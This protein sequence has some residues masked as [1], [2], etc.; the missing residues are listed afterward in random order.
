MVHYKLN[1]KVN[2]F[3]HKKNITLLYFLAKYFDHISKHG[4]FHPKKKLVGFLTL[5]NVKL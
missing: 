4:D 1:M 5:E 3:S 2:F